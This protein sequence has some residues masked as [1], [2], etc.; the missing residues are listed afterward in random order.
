[1]T[2]LV[3]VANPAHPWAKR[4]SISYQELLQA[5]L[6]LQ[7]QGSG[8]TA[9]LQDALR[10]HGVNLSRLNIVMELGLQESAKA[11]VR[12]G[13]GLTI[14][15]LLGV[16]EDLETGRLVRI[17]IED[18]ELKRAIYVCYNRS[19][20]LSILA[21]TFLDFANRQKNDL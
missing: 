14:I 15:S 11:A 1:M 3:L 20:P 8:A 16:R 12:A 2:A 9:V 21:Q 4:S 17:S 10:E 5:P 7:Q 13:F 6:I 18:F 19:N